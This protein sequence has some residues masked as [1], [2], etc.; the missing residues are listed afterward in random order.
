LSRI[1]TKLLLSETKYSGWRQYK[2]KTV[3]TWKVVLAVLVFS[4]KI[5]F[6]LQQTEAKQQCSYVKYV[7]YV[8]APKRCFCLLITL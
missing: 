5:C 1:A 3:V 2:C 8:C 6:L 7:A 4:S